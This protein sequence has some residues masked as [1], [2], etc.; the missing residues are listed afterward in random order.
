MK[1]NHILFIICVLPCG[2]K[3]LGVIGTTFEI[4]EK[5]LLKVIEERLQ[6]LQT[7]GKLAE[8]QKELQE[9]VR[10]SIDRPR[11]V[12][13]LQKTTTYQSRDYDPSFVLDKDIKDHEG[14]M[15]ATA[16][17]K[18][19]PLV[20]H[21]FGKPLLLIDGDDALQVNWALSQEGK[22]VLTQGTPLQLTKEHKRT[23]FF[24]QG[25]VL[26]KKLGLSKVPTRV[27]Q[28][29]KVLL[30]EEITLKDQANELYA[31]KDQ[32]DE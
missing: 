32:D 10:Q 14:N 12:E 2:A 18:Y 26:V 28:K 17:T 30:I 5:S 25:G 23:F 29:D 13:G 7:S 27:S 9:R 8:H 22:I 4:V 15:I 3:D 16:G 11:P 31:N 21:S 20:Y 1:L 24:D 6:D 19:N